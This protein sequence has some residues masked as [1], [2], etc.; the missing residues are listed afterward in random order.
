VPPSIL[1]VANQKGGVGKTTTA[2]SVGAALAEMGRTGV[3]L[4]G[5]LLEGQRFE[6]LHVELA[7]RLVVRD[8]TAAPARAA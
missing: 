6:T 1:A 5:R 7:T 3:S 4:L 2:V 8:S